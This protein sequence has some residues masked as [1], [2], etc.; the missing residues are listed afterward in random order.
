M[1]S[2][3]AS[4]WWNSLSLILSV[5]TTSDR[6]VPTMNYIIQ[7]QPQT[8]TD[9]L[10][11]TGSSS[12]SPYKSHHPSSLSYWRGLT[13]SPK[14]Q[15]GYNVFL[16]LSFVR[17]G[18]KQMKIIYLYLFF[19]FW[20]LW[21]FV[22]IG[23]LSLVSLEKFFLVEKIRVRVRVSLGCKEQGLLSSCGAQASRRGGFSC[24]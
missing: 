8:F 4:G 3:S 23:R 16:N 2:V 5:P 21:V 19:F 7:F 22:A 13:Y 12:P 14:P 1:C 10:E 20:L 11:A 17:T 15:A 6:L 18:T 9:S 24:C